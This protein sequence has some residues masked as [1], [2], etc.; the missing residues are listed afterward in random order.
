MDIEVFFTISLIVV[1]CSVL[2]LGFP[3]AFSLAGVSV[4]FVA[5]GGVLG[6]IDFSVLGAI[7]LRIFGSAILNIVLLAVPMFIFMGVILERSRVAEELLTA[8]ADLL[9]SVPGGLG[10]GVTIVGMLLAASTG[11]VGATVVTMGLLALP[12]MIKNRYDPAL[13]TGSICASGTLGQIIPPSIVLIILGDQISNAYVLAENSLGN[14]SPEPVSIGDLFVGA[15]FPGLILVSLYLFYQFLIATFQPHKSPPLPAS[16]RKSFKKI[17]PQLLIAFFPP[18][19]LILMVLGSILIGFAT[20]TEASAVGAVGAI[21]LACVNLARLNSTVPISNNKIVL[22][23]DSITRVNNLKVP[24]IYLSALSLFVL[25]ILSAYFDLSLTRNNL[26]AVD[27]TVIIISFFFTSL[28]A[29]GLLISLWKLFR[30]GVL[31]KSCYQTASITTMVFTILIGASFFSVAFRAFGGDEIVK[32]FLVN[33]PG[34]FASQMLVV[35]IV[36]FLLGFII[37]FF[38]ITLIVV[39]I[40]AP[41][42]LLSGISPV[43]LGVMIAMN[44]QTSFLTPPFGFSLF[45]LRGVAPKSIPTSTIYK[46]VIPFIILQII[47]MGVLVLFP[48]IVDYLPRVVFGTDYS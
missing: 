27:F 7:P 13:V 32:E 47:A 4:F 5:I 26:S 25:L 16:K 9:G 31:G 15:I 12:T 35:M 23:I 37:D 14:F 17:I 33:L 38:E 20:P 8:I 18:L 40:I 3:V 1:V 6:V 41:V 22:L 46:G 44:L 45:Y 43:W 28:I 29:W 19:M 48:E 10:Y 24:L 2:L 36:I 30:H 39:P 11:I 42:L 21:Y 34:G